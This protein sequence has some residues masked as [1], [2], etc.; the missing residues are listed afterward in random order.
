MRIKYIPSFDERKEIVSFNQLI[1]KEY[2]EFLKEENPELILV[3]GGDG[4]ML[5]A[6]SKWGEKNIPVLGRSAGT[7]NFINSRF[8]NDREILNK[9]K[10][11]S[12]H[13]DL[14]EVLTIEIEYKDKIYHAVNDVII[15]NGL[16]DWQKFKITSE[17]CF[18]DNFIF[19]GAGI[20]VATPIGSTAFNL[21]NN[22]K[23][24]RLR[25]KNKKPSENWSITN[26]V[27]DAIINDIIYGQELKIEVL[28]Q[29][30]SCKCYIDGTT[31]T[32]DLDIGE[33]IILRPG[34]SYKIAYLNVDEV[35]KRR[36]KLA[37]KKRI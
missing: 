5:H 29:R 24:L 10:I 33:E 7:V 12:S 32:I 27:A 22:G 14:V 2:P 18:F 36:I 23:I 31:N 3:T 28:S 6:L 4:S 17:D 16:M 37:H 20:C 11:D 26:I 9:L 15:G 1:E 21:N 30:S 35:K 8:S 34:I 13:I 25:D 19:N